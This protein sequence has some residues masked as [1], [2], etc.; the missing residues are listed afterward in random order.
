MADC[1]ACATAGAEERSK[2]TEIYEQRRK[3][4]AR[5][6]AS[7]ASDAA[8]GTR[9]V[10]KQFIAQLNEMGVPNLYDGIWES[11]GVD[12]NDK[13]KCPHDLLKPRCRA[14]LLRIDEALWSEIM[15]LF[16]LSTE[17]VWDAPTCEICTGPQR[18]RTLKRKVDDA[19]DFVSPREKRMHL[20]MN[21][22][23]EQY[24]CPI[25]QELPITPVIAEDGRVYEEKDILRW[26]AT[27]REKREN[28]TSPATGAVIGTNLLPA[29]QARNTIETL[30]KSGAIE[31][32]IAEAWTKRLEQETIVK[33]MRTLAETGDGDAMWRLGS[34]HES[35]KNGLAEDDALARTWYE[36][37]AAVRHPKG[38]ASFGSCL[39]VGLGGPPDNVL[40]LVIVTEA[41]HL[42]SDYGAYVLG[43]AFCKG[44]CGL[45][46][47]PARAR[48]WLKKIVNNE[49]EI[50]YLADEG[51]AEAKEWLRELDDGAGE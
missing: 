48:F 24:V 36:R 16:D 40:G 21:S 3:L 46:K 34:W 44:I 42:G 35:G 14:K 11:S 26:F 23:A 15:E 5:L 38:M 37:S 27:K 13:I 49:C 25:T 18:A 39:L 10:A 43:Q 45:S 2:A 20:A 29:V 30:I 47:D 31:G 19:S 50:K 4:L 51:I 9:V 33:E 32:E 22:I 41:A 17:L 1:V 12:C 28:P 6:Q 8:A 7:A